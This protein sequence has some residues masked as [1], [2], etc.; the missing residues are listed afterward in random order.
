MDQFDLKI[1]QTRVVAFLAQNKDF[2]SLYCGMA[3]PIQQDSSLVEAI[4]VCITI[5]IALKESDKVDTIIVQTDNKN[6]VELILKEKEKIRTRKN[7]KP[8]DRPFDKLIKWVVDKL[9]KHKSLKVT[10]VPHIQNIAVDELSNLA[11]TLTHVV[12]AKK[13]TLETNHYEMTRK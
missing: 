8:I 1:Y 2:R 3:W 12:T 10:Y 7:K 9:E 11:R 6:L 13:V 4:G 5:Q